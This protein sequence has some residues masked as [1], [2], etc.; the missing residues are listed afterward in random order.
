MGRS[1]IITFLFS[2]QDLIIRKQTMEIIRYTDRL[3]HTRLALVNGI[4][5]VILFSFSIMRPELF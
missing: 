5:V 3:R 2:M 4:I 1:E